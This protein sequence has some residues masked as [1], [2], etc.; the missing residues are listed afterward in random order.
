MAQTAA[1]PPAAALQFDP[2]SAPMRMSSGVVAI[3]NDYVI[4]DYDMDQRIALFIATSGVRPTK[5]TLSQ[6]RL[7]ILRS[8]EDEILELQEANKHKISVTKADV[9][10]AI[11]N[12]AEDNRISVD[13]ILMTI[14]QAGVTVDTFRQQI[15]AQVVWQ[16]VVT[17]RY[18]TDILITDQQ[19][20]EAMDRLRKGADR[21]QFLVSE[22]FMAVDRPEEDMGVRVSAE[23]ISQQLNQGAPF[24]SVAGQFSQSPSAADGGDIGWVLQG[25][26][27][28]ELD[29]ALDKMRPGQVSAAVRAEGGY[30]VLMLRDRREQL[31]MKMEDLQPQPPPFDPAQPLPLDRLLIPLVNADDTLKTRAMTLANNVRTQVRTCADLPTV[32]NQLQGTVFARLGEMKPNELAPELRDKLALTEPGRMVEPFYSQAGIE[33][34]MR[35]DPPL[36][37]LVAFEL[38]TRQELQQQLF[39][40]QM[41]LLAKSYL[42][43]LRR[44]A[45][46][47]TR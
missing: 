8:L 15:A 34:I 41:T 17:A 19:V 9:D 36:Q 12:L 44:D 40:Q 28:E 42:R 23:Q 35:C 26:L 24:A 6:I 20:D 14:K 32:A 4:S 18:G 13:Q 3:V 5:E 25:T 29:Q 10:K 11:Q 47:Q 46:V 30:Y 33:L 38:P 16:R 21:P 1:A 31:G 43:D 22:I 37:R 7:Q 39:V 2:T 45:V 27:A